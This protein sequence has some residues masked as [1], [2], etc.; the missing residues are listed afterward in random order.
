MLH[1]VTYKDVVTQGSGLLRRL[2]PQT[3][4][5]G[6]ITQA[7]NL[8]PI[9]ALLNTAFPHQPGVVTWVLQYL[10]F[11]RKSPGSLGETNPMFLQD[12]F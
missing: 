3:N 11:S 1:F 4:V 6:P 8:E 9:E 12:G 10:Q 5:A 7:C 2:L